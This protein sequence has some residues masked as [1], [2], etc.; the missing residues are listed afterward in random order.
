MLLRNK[1]KRLIKVNHD[2]KSY[3]IKCGESPAVDVPDA[4]CKS[5]FVRALI[6]SGDL[7]QQVAPAE[8]SITGDKS[9]SELIQE[10]ELLGIE[11]NSRDTVKTLTEKIEAF[12]E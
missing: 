2:G 5:S 4:A 6:N 12:D 10:C 9:K 7:I 1:S 8:P 11:T 3:L